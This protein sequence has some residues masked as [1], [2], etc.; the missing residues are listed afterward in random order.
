MPPQTSAEVLAC[1]VGA[2]EAGDAAD[3]RMTVMKNGHGLEGDDAV[4]AL[5][6]A[7]VVDL[8][9]GRM[10]A[11]SLDGG[12]THAI[13][14]GLRQAQ[15][16]ACSGEEIDSW[17]NAVTALAVTAARADDVLLVEAL[18]RYEPD[19]VMK[20]GDGTDDHKGHAETTCEFFAD[21]DAPRCEKYVKRHHPDGRLGHEEEALLQSIEMRLRKAAKQWIRALKLRARTSET[22]SV[23]VGMR[24]SMLHDV[25]SNGEVSVV[26]VKDSL[27]FSAGNS[28]LG[29]P[30]LVYFLKE[31]DDLTH[32]IARMARVLRGCHLGVPPVSNCKAVM[33]QGSLIDIVAPFSKLRAEHVPAVQVV[34][35]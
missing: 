5:Q 8:A 27:V 9:Q 3:V 17:N 31:G 6:R 21:L 7:Y 4:V 13:F 35:L 25:L 1:I 24:R 23:E 11:P 19:F 26:A 29:R 30:E 34:Q 28:L 20:R 33:K 12:M 18:M 32:V 14:S 22:D 15:S 10:T 16:L 2:I